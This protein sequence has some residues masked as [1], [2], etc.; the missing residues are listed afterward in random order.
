MKFGEIVVEGVD[1]FMLGAIDVV[2]AVDLCGICGIDIYIFDGEF[3]PTGYPIVLGHEFVGEV[4]V[5]GS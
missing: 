2:V 3:G 1:D 5:L 4:V